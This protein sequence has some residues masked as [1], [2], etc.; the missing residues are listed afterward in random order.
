MFGV[1]LVVPLFATALVSRA[2]QRNDLARQ[3]AYTR[4]IYPDTKN[5]EH[6]A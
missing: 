6:G 1:Q 2:K 5:T 4:E 3:V